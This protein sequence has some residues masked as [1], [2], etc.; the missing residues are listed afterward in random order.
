MCRIARTKAGI[1]FDKQEDIAEK[2]IIGETSFDFC[3]W[4]ENCGAAKLEHWWLQ[5]EDIPLQYRYPEMLKDMIKSFGVLKGF[6][7]WRDNPTDQSKLLMLIECVE[8]DISMLIMVNSG[9][10]HFR[11]PVSKAAEVN[12]YTGAIHI[13]DRN[14]SHAAFNIESAKRFMQT[15]KER[16]EAQMRSEQFSKEVS[17][18]AGTVLDED[19][20]KMQAMPPVNTGIEEFP[21]NA[22]K[23]ISY[24]ERDTER[25]V[26]HNGRRRYHSLDSFKLKRS[27]RTRWVLNQNQERERIKHLTLGDFIPDSLADKTH[28]ASRNEDGSDSLGI[29]SESD[30]EDFAPPDPDMFFLSNA[31]NTPPTWKKDDVYRDVI[32]GSV[33]E[34]SDV[35]RGGTMD[36]GDS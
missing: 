15:E 19:M 7:S 34:D 25:T 5:I 4:T 33:F 31:Q 3:R 27:Q 17:Q 20:R 8:E 32:L 26:Y 30:E 36:L 22:E 35:H 18:R 13:V 1:W 6:S 10:K 9:E 23:A 24:R 16:W 11:M 21:E 2:L 28:E 14:I 12:I 29:P